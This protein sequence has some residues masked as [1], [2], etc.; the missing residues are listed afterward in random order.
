[1]KHS[2]LKQKNIKTSFSLLKFLLMHSIKTGNEKILS[3]TIYK[4]VLLKKHSMKSKN[5]SS[6][7]AVMCSS[8]C[9][10]D[11]CCCATSIA[12]QCIAQCYSFVLLHRHIVNRL[13][14]KHSTTISSTQLGRI[15]LTNGG[16]VTKCSHSLFH[17]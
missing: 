1:M 4:P 10:C 5:N 6:F 7:C 9:G 17:I 8:D 11:E 2:H 12:Q 15:P 13:E 16:C 3:A 14:Y